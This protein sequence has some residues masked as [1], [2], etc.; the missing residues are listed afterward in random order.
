MNVNV[1]IKL[2]D[3]ETMEFSPHPLLWSCIKYVDGQA[4]KDEKKFPF[5]APYHSL[6]KCNTLQCVRNVTTFKENLLHSSSG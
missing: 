5:Y 4:A 3:I 6:L 2:S 1:F